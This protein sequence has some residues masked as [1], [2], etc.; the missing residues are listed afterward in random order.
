MDNLLQRVN[1]LEK[2]IDGE[3]SEEEASH[4]MKSSMK[5]S[6][7]DDEVD[8][9]ELKDIVNNSKPDLLETTSVKDINNNEKLQFSMK[10]DLTRRNSRTSKN[11][12]AS[13]TENKK[14]G[15]RYQGMPILIEKESLNR[16]SDLVRE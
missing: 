14:T 12:K 6:R 5:F 9:E 15:I 4:S 13:S 1:R 2:M 10:K 16:A 3:G 7:E 11:S 8:P